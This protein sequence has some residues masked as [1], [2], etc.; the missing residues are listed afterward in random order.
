MYYY[1]ISQEKSSNERVPFEIQPNRQYFVLKS[2]CRLNLKQNRTSLN[3]V[4]VL[5]EIHLK[6]TIHQSPHKR[7]CVFPMVIWPAFR[8]GQ[9]RV[10]DHPYHALQFKILLFWLNFKLFRLTICFDLCHAKYAM[11]L[12]HLG[13]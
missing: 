4:G 7:G 11:S 3:I 5:F 13:A 12:D 8:M 2:F 1:F 10:N 6:G 9:Y